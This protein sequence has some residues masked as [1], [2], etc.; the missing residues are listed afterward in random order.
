MRCRARP[1]CS[2]SSTDLARHLE[3]GRA[4]LRLRQFADAITLTPP[5]LAVED[6]ALRDEIMP[7][8]K[9]PAANAMMG[10]AFTQQ[11]AAVMASGSGARRPRASF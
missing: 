6:P 10:G 11:N 2:S 1:A 5:G 7:L 9:D 4:C 3:A 8:R